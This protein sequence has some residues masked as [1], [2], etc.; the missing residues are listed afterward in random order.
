[1]SVWTYNIIIMLS[2]DEEALYTRE[3][4]NDIV[5]TVRSQLWHEEVRKVKVLTLLGLV[6]GA[7]TPMSDTVSD[8]LVAASFFMVGDCLG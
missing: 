8:S 4:D 2:G 1:M 6:L 5:V 7:A 3:H